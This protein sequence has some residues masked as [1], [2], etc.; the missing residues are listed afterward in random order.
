[1]WVSVL[2]ASALATILSVLPST[3]PFDEQ[4]D[5]FRARL[6]MNDGRATVRLTVGVRVSTSVKMSGWRLSGRVRVRGQLTD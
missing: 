1:M 3:A 6:R 4:G 2:A 5:G